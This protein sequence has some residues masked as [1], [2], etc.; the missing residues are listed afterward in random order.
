M[1]FKKKSPHTFHRFPRALLEWLCHQDSHRLHLFSE[2]RFLQVW[3]TQILVSGTSKTRW[4]DGKPEIF[5][6]A[7]CSAVPPSSSWS[8]C[9]PSRPPRGSGFCFPQTFNCSFSSTE[10]RCVRTTGVVQIEVAHSIPSRSSCRIVS[11]KPAVKWTKK[12]LTGTS[13]QIEVAHSTPVMG[14]L[15]G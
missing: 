8:P 12:F 5:H 2:L 15:A 3:E 6:P 13:V 11:N 7:W 4:D 14:L 10:K 1:I 9:T